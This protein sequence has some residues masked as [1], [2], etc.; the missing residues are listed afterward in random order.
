[1]T[2]AFLMSCFVFSPAPYQAPVAVVAVT[3]IARITLRALDGFDIVY[4]ALSVTYFGFGEGKFDIGEGT[5]IGP[6]GE[7]EKFPS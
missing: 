5:D 2:R 1:M 7:V 3:P 6:R 4:G